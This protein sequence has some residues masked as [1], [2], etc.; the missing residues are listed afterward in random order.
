MTLQQ[1]SDKIDL[2]ICLHGQFNVTIRYRGGEYRC[3][4]N[5]TLAYD[6]I[7]G[8]DDWNSDKEIQCGYTLKQA[9]QALWDECKRENDID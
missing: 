8:S 7:K 6:R 5:N 1:L 4:S 3:K 9:Y 2:G